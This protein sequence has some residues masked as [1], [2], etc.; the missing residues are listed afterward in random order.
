MNQLPP[1]T[2]RTDAFRNRPF[3]PPEEVLR[4]IPP[5]Y[6]TEDIPAEKKLVYAHYFIPAQQLPFDWFVMELSPEE[7]WT[8]FGFVCLK[9]DTQNAEFGY[10][11]LWELADIF[12]APGIPAV[13]RNEE[14]MRPTPWAEVREQWGRKFA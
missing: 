1:F 9:G 3:M 5:L 4:R 7:N 2:S 10:F 6:A 14:L 11:A 13:I 12:L 8:A